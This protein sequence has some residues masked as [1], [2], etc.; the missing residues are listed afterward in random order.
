MSNQETTTTEP[1]PRRQAAGRSNGALGKGRKSP[2]G[3]AR[4]AQ[5]AL[6]HGLCC[7][8]PRILSND[9][10]P[11]FK[12]LR[13]NFIAQLQPRTPAELAMVESIV[14]AKWN[15]DRHNDLET[16]ILNLEIE[17][18]RIQADK[19]N[20][21]SLS[22]PVVRTGALRSA[23]T[24]D[25]AMDFILRAKVI[26]ER[27][28]HRRINTYLKL[29][30][31]DLPQTEIEPPPPPAPQPQQQSQPQQQPQPQP[32]PILPF[33]ITNHTIFN[34][35]KVSVPSPEPSEPIPKQ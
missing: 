18:V 7:S 5:N 29:R 35:T 19:N 30:Q 27:N 34:K 16:D 31:L 21:P 2:A 11:A 24:V 26:N 20:W 9:E 14:E 4:S 23:I 22:T 3:L 12:L 8:K 1:N 17:N 15:Y 28:F 33:P 32:E 13:R 25:R 10:K 6:K